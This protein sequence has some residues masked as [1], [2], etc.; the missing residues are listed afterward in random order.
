MIYSLVAMITVLVLVPLLLEAAMK[1]WDRTI[2]FEAYREINQEH[3]SESDDSSSGIKRAP[4]SEHNKDARYIDL[5]L[6]VVIVFSS[7]IGS[8]AILLI[9][10]MLITSLQPILSNLIATITGGFVS[11]AIA[12]EVAF[13]RPKNILFGATA[14]GCTILVTMIILKYGLDVSIGH[15]PILIVQFFLSAFAGI[16]GHIVFKR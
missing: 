15:H 8:I 11:G 13:K 12:T 1:G 10:G 6:G 3:K 9:Y 4:Q 5:P 7:L 14:G 2:F 16:T